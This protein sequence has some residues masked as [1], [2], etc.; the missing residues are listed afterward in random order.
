VRLLEFYLVEE[1]NITL[2]N[3]LTNKDIAF[4]LDGKA[5]YIWKGTQA[6]DLDEISA[7]KV[8][9]LI[10]ERFVDISFE[11]IPDL[12]ISEA[13]NPKIIQIKTEISRRLP[14]PA[15][16]KIK[17]KP[18]SIFR[19]IR[20]KIQEFKDYE[21]SREWRR[22]LSNLTNLWKLSI[23]N[24]IILGISLIL[25][26]NQSFF[27]FLIGDY[28]LIIALIG[29]FLIFLINFIFIVFPMKFPISILSFGEEVS[30]TLPPQP[31]VPEKAIPS[32]KKARVPP[33]KLALEIGPLKTPKIAKKSAKATEEGEEYLS[34]EDKELGIPSIPEAPKKKEKI[35]IDS[36]GLST[37]LIEK[38]KK[39][40]S[41]AA[42]V[43]LVN[44]DRC[45]EVIPVPVPKKAVSKSELPVVPISFIHKNSQGKD[46]HCITI[47]I[48]HDFDIR[49]QRISDVVLSSD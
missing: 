35:T 10:K 26:F 36:P 5:G 39:M 34:E 47:H 13:D 32:A 15:V 46:E 25:M 38:M 1:D 24:I 18:A 27:H 11:L 30:R 3:K 6:T 28:F 20:N 23:F 45:K 33:Q 22:K 19:K 17:E 9:E 37:E 48:D 14:T 31:K 49:R 44:C 43:V 21:N 42:Q 12:E 4:I 8:E 41:K 2:S 29:L 40:E 16:M 7:K